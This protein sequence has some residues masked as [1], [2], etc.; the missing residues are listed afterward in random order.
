MRYGEGEGKD[1]TYTLNPVHD[2]VMVTFADL[3]L[4]VRS[5]RTEC[6]RSHKNSSP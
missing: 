3:S 4:S 1:I 2:L 6:E 5:S